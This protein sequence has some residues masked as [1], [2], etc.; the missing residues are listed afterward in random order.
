MA[1]DSVL[2]ALMDPVRLKL[3]QTVVDATS[4]ASR[5]QQQTLVLRTANER[6]IIAAHGGASVNS[7][8]MA[9]TA[10]TLATLAQEPDLDA[11]LKFY[12]GFFKEVRAS[13]DSLKVA[14]TKQAKAATDAADNK[15]AAAS[16]TQ[17]PE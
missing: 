7:K 1:M 14:A 2:W 8:S 16:S 4:L 17:N 6:A 11:Q 13:S 3:F 9:K 10:Q 12:A 5:L 15:K